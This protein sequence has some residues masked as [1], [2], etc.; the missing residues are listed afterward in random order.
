MVPSTNAA[1]SRPRV[2]IVGGGF[3]G[4]TAARA[5]RR[6]PVRVTLIDRRNHHLFQPLL[7][8]IATATL[9]PADIAAP[10]RKVLSRQRNAEVLLAEVVSVDLARRV[11]VLRDGEVGYDW[12]ILA[13]G[14]T[15]SYF[16]HDEWASIAPGLKTVE[17]AIEI[18]RRFLLAFEAAEREA[19]P[20]ARRADLTFVV[21]GGGPTGV[22]LAGAMAEVARRTIPRDFRSIDTTT[23]RIILVEGLGRLLSTF[24]PELSERAE[25]D[26]QQLG[27]EVRRNA[28]VTGVDAGGVWIGQERIEAHGVIWAAGVRA[29]PLGATLGVPLDRAGR[30]IVGPDLSIPGHPEVFVIGDMAAAK[31][32]Q[33]G[34]PVPGVAQG[35]I[36]MGAFAAGII[37]GEAAAGRPDTP[38]RPTAASRPAFRYKDKGVLAT[39]GRAKAVG[40]I[41]RWKLSGFV[42]WAIWALVHVFQLIGHRSRMVVMLEWAWAYVTYQ[43]GARLITGETADLHLH[44]PRQ[45]AGVAS[46]SVET[47]A[48]G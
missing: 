20:E 22:E 9:S 23:A 5:L 8:Q 19:D 2:V 24:P 25:R 15:H 33:T 13:T 29:S 3:G 32:A 45:A 42:A 21:V 4:L 26:L 27:V 41:G 10:I 39:I 18:R 17:D 37:A 34:M 38:G 48:A 40:V 1:D 30:V 28:R 14:A 11:V 7:Y 35:A 46:A 16:G 43:R 47:S 6:A 12:L 44:R 36:Q 31:D